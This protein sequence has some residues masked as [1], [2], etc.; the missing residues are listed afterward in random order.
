MFDFPEATK[1]Y[2]SMPK[3]LFYKYLNSDPTLKKAFVEEIGSIIWINTLSPET[4]AIE[5]GQQVKEI[6]IVEIVL[7]RQAIG[8]KLIEIVNRE[9]DQYTIFMTRY[10]DWKQYWCCD[11]QTMKALL[12]QFYCQN[13]YQSNWMIEKEQNLRIEGENLDQVFAGFFKQ[14]T[15][16]PLTDKHRPIKNEVPKP[17]ITV[18]PADDQQKLKELA[19][20]IKELETQ[21]DEEAEFG[22]KLK[23]V[24]QIEKVKNEIHSLKRVRSAQVELIPIENMVNDQNIAETIWP[25]FP[26][27]PTNLKK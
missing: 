26:N 23:L 6:A 19:A 15:G 5:A 1:I 7:K 2:R 21:L 18:E 22:R 20:T 27:R 14:I 13:Y 16:K 24:S 10:E 9:M 12:G 4:M 8:P 17:V 11:H 3:E 25:F